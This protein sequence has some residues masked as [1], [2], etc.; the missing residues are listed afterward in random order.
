MGGVTRGWIQ[1]VPSLVAWVLWKAYDGLQPSKDAMKKEVGSRRETY[2]IEETEVELYRL[3][4]TLQLL[5][6]LG[7][8]PYELVYARPHIDAIVA[9]LGEKHAPSPAGHLLAVFDR[10]HAHALQPGLSAGDSGS[11]WLSDAA[12]LE[13]F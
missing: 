13:L 6:Q 5:R 2:K 1:V 11:K 8:E 7:L 9:A 12:F 3:R 4:D 10:A